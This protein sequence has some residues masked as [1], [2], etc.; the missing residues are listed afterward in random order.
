ME[1][2]T[3]QMGGKIKCLWLVILRYLS[4]FEN[5]DHLFEIGPLT[6]VEKK[7]ERKK[8]TFSTHEE[9]N[10]AGHIF[11]KCNGWLQTLSSRERLNTQG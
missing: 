3:A 7:K 5:S 8:E 9:L 6:F 2:V 1:G 10:S 4:N 11:H